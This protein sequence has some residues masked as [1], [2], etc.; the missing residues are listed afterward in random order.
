[1]TSA[2]SGENSSADRFD[3]PLPVAY[4]RLP[5]AK[6]DSMVLVPGLP[7]PVYINPECSYIILETDPPGLTVTYP[8]ANTDVF[9]TFINVDSDRQ[10]ERVLDG[11]LDRISHNLN[12]APANTL[13]PDENTVL[14]V[15]QTGTQTPVQLL[16]VKDNTV[17]T[18]TA[19]VH[20]PRATAAYDSIAPLFGILADDLARTL[21]PF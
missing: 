14:V 16:A 1:M 18:A 13:H 15:A 4:P 5:V 11:R 12:G 7:V 3:V 2:C 10:R 17:V 19:F 6:A 21:N 8:G 20:D 9:Y